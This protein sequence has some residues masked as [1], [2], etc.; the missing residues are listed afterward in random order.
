MFFKPTIARLTMASA[1]VLGAA[2]VSLPAQTPTIDLSLFRAMAWRPVGP[3]NGGPTTAASGV[4]GAP[5]VF[6]AGTENGGLFR[7]TD[8]GR[9]WHPIFDDQPIGSIGS[10]AVAA[11]D[12]NIVYVGTGAEPGHGRTVTGNGLYR[13][14]D[15]GRTW[16]HLGLSDSHHM[17]TV[18][19]DPTNA[20]RVIVAASGSTFA[21]NDARG[22]YRSIDGGRTF[23]RVLSGN[24]HTGA[25][26]LAFDPGDASTLYATLLDVR[27]N[28]GGVLAH[29]P[30]TGLHKSTDGGTTWRPA[31]NGLP[32]FAADG[33][34]R[35][36]LAVTAASRHRVFALVEAHDRGGLYRSD[37]AGASWTLIN[38]SAD[39]VGP[40][41]DAASV[42]ADPQNSEV[43]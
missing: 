22:V 42:T 6:Y 36:R 20:D 13:S 5:Y 43:V 33:L 17:P 14:N 31:A 8:A 37:D 26:D 30:G 7:T 2:D 4:A 1:V 28:P 39:L 38:A 27:Q 41:T 21:A 25:L 35:I 29:G 18:I 23:E 12:R 32:T 11:S 24:G 10:I 16:S 40:A 9:S 15:A 3:F 19:V 34:R